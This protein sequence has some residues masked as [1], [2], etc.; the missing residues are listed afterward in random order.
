MNPDIAIP[1]LCILGAIFFPIGY[2]ALVFWSESPRSSK[3]WSHRAFP[4]WTEILKE[5][6]RDADYDN[7]L[8]KLDEY[9]PGMEE[10]EK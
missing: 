9:Y 7:A 10:M 5:R 6:K 8:K 3:K 2:M 4:G 1:A